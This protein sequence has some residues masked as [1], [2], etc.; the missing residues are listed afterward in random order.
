MKRDSEESKL[1][2]KSFTQ[3][4]QNI[5]TR[6]NVLVSRPEYRLLVVSRQPFPEIPNTSQAVKI[7]TYHGQTESIIFSLPTL[8]TEAIEKMDIQ[9]L[10]MKKES[11]DLDDFISSA[12]KRESNTEGYS[13]NN[14]LRWALDEAQVGNFSNEKQSSENLLEVRPEQLKKQQ[15]NGRAKSGGQKR[16]EG[17]REGKAHG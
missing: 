10:D 1:S 16:L 17:E 3:L 13:I 4:Y 2:V 6:M 12:L 11:Q 15:T 7:N 14:Y 9:I 8:S 5:M